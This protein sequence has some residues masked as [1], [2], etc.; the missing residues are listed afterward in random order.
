MTNIFFRYIL[1]AC[2]LLSL[3]SCNRK[4][5]NPYKANATAVNIL[6]FPKMEHLSMLDTNFVEDVSFIKLETNDDCL[7]SE[8]HKIVFF[9]NSFYVLDKKYKSLKQFTLEG[10]F[11]R[12]IG[13]IGQGPGE[14]NIIKTFYIN[15]DDSTINIVDFWRLYK[16]KLDGTFERKINIENFSENYQYGYTSL[17]DVVY[18]GQGHLLGHGQITDEENFQILSIEEKNFRPDSF[19]ID[20]PVAPNTSLL[21]GGTPLYLIEREGKVLFIPYMSDTFFS[22]SNGK[23]EAVLTIE[24][25]RKVPDA[26][27]YIKRWNNITDLIDY[28]TSFYINLLKDG[29][30]IGL[31]KVIETDSYYYLEDCYNSF[32]PSII[33]LKKENRQGLLLTEFPSSVPCFGDISTSFDNTFVRVW[34]TELIADFK[35]LINN[36]K[37]S[38][39]NFPQ[40]M[41]DALQEYD[42]DD[43]NPILILYKMKK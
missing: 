18:T 25:G 5:N 37:Y 10:K 28:G 9:N 33:L 17:I 11:I 42:S 6:D 27:L 7:L 26:D 13:R 2:L 14:Y 43:D 24:N 8:V 16:Y 21:I 29:Y 19:R 30:S 41:W 38:R 22:Y 36:G 20:Y 35:S 32:I 39:F 31:R 23:T 34:D 40:Q 12:N 15:P 4:T 3:L 1:F